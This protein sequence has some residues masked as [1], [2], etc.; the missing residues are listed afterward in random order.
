MEEEWKRK[1]KGENEGECM[2][3]MKECGNNEGL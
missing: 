3:I 2:E 1:N